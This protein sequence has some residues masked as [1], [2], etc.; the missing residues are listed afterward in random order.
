[1]AGSRPVMA[2]VQLLF[3]VRAVVLAY[4][5]VVHPS[6]PVSGDRSLHLPLD[7]FAE[8]VD[9]L[10]DAFEIV[11]LRDLLRIP[12]FPGSRPRAAITFDDAYQGAVSLAIPELNRLGLPATIF[13]CS[14]WI[15]GETPW[16]DGLAD[17]LGLDST[18]RSEALH[19]CAGRSDRVYKLARKL[20]IERSH[21]P[22]GHRI[23]SPAEI[24][25]VVELGAIAVGV[26]SRSHPNLTRLDDLE[27]HAE[28]EGSLEATMQRY[29]S[30]IP[31][32]AYPYGI[33]DKRVQSAAETVGFEAALRVDGGPLRGS[34][35]DPFALPRVNIPRDVSLA[36]FRIRCAGLR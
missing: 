10:S 35:W 1:M 12:S 9:W 26:H 16:W 11:A 32:L 17:N 5:N 15:G 4:H 30:A 24:A 3:P 27:L 25:E 34:D 21:M 29:D 20:G 13:V 18:T 2:A 33:S 8:Q 22:A 28:L 7:R 19:R 14:D 23:A 31:W 6:S 36:R